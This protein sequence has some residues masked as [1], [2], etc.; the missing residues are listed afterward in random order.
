MKIGIIGNLEG[1]EE[2]GKNGNWE[3]RDNRD[4]MENKDIKKCMDNVNGI[5]Q[6]LP[7]HN[8]FFCIIADFAIAVIFHPAIRSLWKYVK[9][10]PR[11]GSNP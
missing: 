2:K 6:V 10:Y 7:S 4:N 11:I 8:I 9:K 3:N 5:W 1:K